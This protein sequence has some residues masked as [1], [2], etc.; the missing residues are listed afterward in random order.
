MVE[1]LK[2]TFRCRIAKRLV[3][4]GFGNHRNMLIVG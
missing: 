3:Y 4:V 1:A 2:F